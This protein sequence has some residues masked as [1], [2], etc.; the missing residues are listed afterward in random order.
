MS[1]KKQNRFKT[2]I[3]HFNTF[4]E[5]YKSQA[6]E[7]AEKHFLHTTNKTACDAL[8]QSFVWDKTKEGFEYWETFYLSI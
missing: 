3:E 2:V 6:I 4:P 5:P 8:M 7:N 1:I